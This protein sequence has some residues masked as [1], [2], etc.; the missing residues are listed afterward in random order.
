VLET[1]ERSRR[2]NVVLAAAPSDPLE[3][4]LAVAASS[5]IVPGTHSRTGVI[6][7]YHWFGE[8]CRDTLISLPGL[9]LVTGDFAAAK[10]TLSAVTR[11]FSRGM[12]PNRFDERTGK[13]EYTSAD[14]SLWFIYAVHKFLGYTSDYEFVR[15]ALYDKM[16]EVIEHYKKGTG[17]G[18]AMDRNGLLDAGSATNQMTWM[19]VTV[20]GQP[21]TPRHGKAVEVNALWYNALKVVADLAR[22]FGDERAHTF[23]AL[24][25]VV[26]RSFQATFWN[27]DG[28][29]LFD[30]VRKGESDSSLRPNQILA[31]SLPYGLLEGERA[32]GVLDCVDKELLTPFGMRTLSRKNPAYRGKHEGNPASRDEAYHQGTVWAWLLGPFITAYFRVR[33]RSQDTIDAARGFIEPFRD[34]LRQAGLG[35]VSEIFDGDPPYTPRGCISKALSVAELLRAYRE[36]IL[37]GTPGT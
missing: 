24:A 37:G 3:A 11:H 26:R 29:Y 4:S 25:T 7:G 17:R 33:G 31:V 18:I 22:K 9:M 15:A 5:F 23:A 10:G 21:V 14:A 12:L 20:A 8:Y 34:H 32:A 30:C 28:G 19:N 27:E 16:T 35:T 6:S 36:D 13:P 1:R 2:A